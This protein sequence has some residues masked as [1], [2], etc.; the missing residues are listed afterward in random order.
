MYCNVRVDGQDIK[1]QTRE[2]FQKA[3]SGCESYEEYT[4][5]RY[6]CKVEYIRDEGPDM[7]V[8]ISSSRPFLNGKEI[9]MSIDDFKKAREF[10]F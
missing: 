2:K 3:Y 1:L 8:R 9:R 7:I 10:F 6:V 5:G 4:R